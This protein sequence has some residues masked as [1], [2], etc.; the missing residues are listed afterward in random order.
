MPGIL[1]GQPTPIRDALVANIPPAPPASQSVR[2]QAGARTPPAKETRRRLYVPG[3]PDGTYGRQLTPED[4]ARIARQRQIGPTAYRAEIRAAEEA[5]NAAAAAPKPPTVPEQ[6]EIM[7]GSPAWAEVHH[8]AFQQW[9]AAYTTALSQAGVAAV[10]R[11]L[12]RPV[13]AYEI[14]ANPTYAATAREARNSPANEAAAAAVADRAVPTGAALRRVAGANA[15][16]PGP[17]VPA[18]EQTPATGPLG[19]IPPLAI[20]GLTIR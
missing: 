13:T 20:P 16:S 18:S 5:R 3:Y 10:A 1:L 12:G 19:R 11:Q 4:Y 7:P 8:V 9:Y 15:V 17:P 6:P 2:L 14:A